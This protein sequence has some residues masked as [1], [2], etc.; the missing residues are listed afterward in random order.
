MTAAHA[1]AALTGTAA[2][3]AVWDWLAE[4]ADPEIPVLSVVD[5]GIVR[6]VCWRG[7][8]AE[9]TLHVALSPTYSGCPA[10]AVIRRD[11][12]SA[13]RARGVANLELEV[14]LAPPW[15]TDWITPA[16][17]EKLHAYGIAP[18]SQPRAV[19]CPRC[20]AA[21]V[22]LVSRFGSTPCKALY[23]C[24]AC[25]EPFDHFKCH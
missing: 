2:A 14:R 10:T 9:R 13:L 11:V 22:Q 8:G 5:L 24:N 12:E 19:V 20:S 18:P 17:R 21:D 4:V 25:R 6:E 23:R 1:S 16:G 15:S 3:G 7:A